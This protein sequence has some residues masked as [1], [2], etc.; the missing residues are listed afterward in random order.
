VSDDVGRRHDG[1]RNDGHDG[2]P[3]RLAQMM[4]M[5]GEMMKAMGEVMM[6]YGKMME[7]ARR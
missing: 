4:Q 2:I 6:K 3:E 7:G 1:R 5:R